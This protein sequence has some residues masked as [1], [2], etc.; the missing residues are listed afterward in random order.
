MLMKL[1]RGFYASEEGNQSMEDYEEETEGIAS[2]QGHAK[3]GSSRSERIKITPIRLEAQWEAKQGPGREQTQT[4]QR[5][6]EGGCEKQD[7]QVQT[8]NKASTVPTA[9]LA[10]RGERQTD[11]I[12]ITE[13]SCHADRSV[14]LNTGK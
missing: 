2:R 4:K 3:D 7:E 8:R 1:Q 10:E 12:G 5:R 6:M 14:H 11:F 13:T 9:I